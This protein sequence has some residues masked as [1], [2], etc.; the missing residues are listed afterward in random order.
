MDE[1]ANGV[2]VQVFSIA[3]GALQLRQVHL[4]RVRSSI[5]GL[6]GSIYP[7]CDRIAMPKLPRLPML[8]VRDA[9]AA[10]H[11]PVLRVMRPCG[12]SG[13]FAADQAPVRVR[14][15]PR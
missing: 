10:G 13:A 5:Q 2:L 14:R 1:N 3:N 12:G 9:R 11:A 4:S 6:S 8:P 7:R 15:G